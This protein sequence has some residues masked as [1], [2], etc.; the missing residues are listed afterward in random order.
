MS[1]MV[2]LPAQDSAGFM[3]MTMGVLYAVVLAFVVFAVWEQFA[4]SEQAVTAE[5]AVL[6][7]VFRD[8]QTVPARY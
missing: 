1:R 7:S 4:H 3:F 2:G 8:T 6:V 5:A